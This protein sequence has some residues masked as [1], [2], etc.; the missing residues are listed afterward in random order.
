MEIPP[1]EASRL[2]KEGNVKVIDVREVYEYEHGHLPDSINFPMSEFSE[3]ILEIVSKDNKVI[4]VCS[5][6][7]RSLDCAQRFSNL[8]Y[9]DVCSVTGGL[10]DFILVTSSPL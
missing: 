8:G 3:K 9:K 10:T 1:Q 5:G 2:L 6:G 4:V 7:F